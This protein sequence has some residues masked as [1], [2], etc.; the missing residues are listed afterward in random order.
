MATEQATTI[1]RLRAAADWL[2]ATELPDGVFVIVGQGPK[3]SLFCHNT[4]DFRAV[5]RIVGRVTKEPGQDTYGMILVGTVADVVPVKIWP[6]A[7]V[8]KQVQTGTKTIQR[9]EPV[10]TRTVT[11]T[12]PV[13]EWDC[14]PV[15]A[16]DPEAVSA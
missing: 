13:F 15:L 1:D 3:L 8:C 6:P 7:G 2:E 10:T 12:I 5:R 14:G 4:E 9:E 16:D 11:E